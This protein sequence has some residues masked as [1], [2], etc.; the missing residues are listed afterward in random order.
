MMKW[1]SNHNEIKAVVGNS[2]ETLML[3]KPG[4]AKI[5]QFSNHFI[6]GLQFN[7]CRNSMP[8]RERSL[9]GQFPY[10]PISEMVNPGGSFVAHTIS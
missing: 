8:R 9:T 7:S 1:C 3:Q 10:L 5:L 4:T 2:E 6:L